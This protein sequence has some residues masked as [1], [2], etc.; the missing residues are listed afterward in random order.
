MLA[1]KKNKVEVVILTS[2]ISNIENIDIKKY[3]KENPILKVPKT[4]KF[5]DRFFRK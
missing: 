3:N 2:E 4:N 1:K 5:H